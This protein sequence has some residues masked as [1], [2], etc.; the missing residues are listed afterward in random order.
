MLALFGGRVDLFLELVR[1][2]AILAFLVRRRL[3]RLSCSAIGFGYGQT[4]TVVHVFLSWRWWRKL[5]VILLEGRPVTAPFCTGS[6][7]FDLAQNPRRFCHTRGIIE[8][9]LPAMLHTLHA[10]GGELDALVEHLHVFRAA[11]FFACRGIDL[12]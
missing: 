8:V 2:G 10:V 12:P 7:G 5:A 9:D 6:A 3:L 11:A 4:A 1:Q